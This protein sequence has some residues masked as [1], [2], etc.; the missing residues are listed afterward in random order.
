[1]YIMLNAKTEI[2]KVVPLIMLINVAIIVLALIL[3]HTVIRISV[4]QWFQNNDSD[5]M[6]LKDKVLVTLTL[7]I[8]VTCVGVFVLT[9]IY[10]N[11]K[12]IRT[13]ESDNML[14]RMLMLII[15]NTFM[16]FAY[17]QH[18]QVTQLDI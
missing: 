15:A 3:G 8:T 1:M 13:T 11:V 12:S 6:T 16:A 7:L 9:I 10:N 4:D 18:F 5:V 17:Y 14:L 2:S